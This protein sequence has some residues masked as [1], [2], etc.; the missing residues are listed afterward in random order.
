MPVTG[1]PRRMCVFCGSRVGASPAYL[2]AARA[3]GGALVD[4]GVGLV[5]GG[6]S[7]GLMGAL[8]D[9]VLDGGGEV[10]GVIPGSMVDRE[11]AHPR[12]T[13]LHV[14]TTMHERK[15]RMYAE[16]DAMIALPGGL[17]TLDELFESLTWNYLGIHDKPCGLL[18][19]AGFWQPLLAWLDGAEAAGF[20]PKPRSGLL[21][22]EEQPATLV[23][24][25]LA[26]SSGVDSSQ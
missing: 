26:Q 5:Y 4:A 25:L 23:A 2:A 1:R 24:R 10:V 19:V 13:T 11:L 6:A 20:L 21:L 7:V 15:A 22:V 8:A 18:E 14:V 3:L 12:L 16:A 17:G 9:T